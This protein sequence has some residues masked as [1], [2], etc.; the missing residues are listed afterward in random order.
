MNIYDISFDLIDNQTLQIN[1]LKNHYFIIVNTA[2]LCGFTGQYRDLELIHNRY[3]IPIIATPCND[4]GNQEPTSDEEV[5]CSVK[6]EFNISFYIT[7]KVNITN[8][9]HPFYQWVYKNG[10]FMSYPRWNFYKYIIDKNGKLLTWFSPLVKPLDKKITR[11]LS[12]L[13]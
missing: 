5:F 9:P 4:F 13:S 6:N 7:K 8:D 12:H 2:S 10:G 3:K 11:I 1:S